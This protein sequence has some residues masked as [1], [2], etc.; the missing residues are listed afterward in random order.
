MD[1]SIGIRYGD[2][3]LERSQDADE[4]YPFSQARFASQAL[5]LLDAVYRD[6]RAALNAE[7]HNLAE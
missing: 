1:V 3:T 5:S 7:L 2:N 6:T 4:I